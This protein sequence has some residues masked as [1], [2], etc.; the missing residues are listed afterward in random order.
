MSTQGAIVRVEMGM[1]PCP[2]CFGPTV[3]QKSDPRNV[4]TLEHGRFIAYETVRVC[5]K[6]CRHPSGELVTIRSDNLSRLVS[7]GCI[8]GYD[9]EVFVGLER[10][11]HHKQREEI[12]AELAK[13]GIILSS[14]EV[15]TLGLRFLK[16]LAELHAS[17]QPALREA[18]ERDGGY[19]LHF[20][21]TGE[22]GRGT[23]LVV[24]DG[25]REWVLGSWKLPTE[26]ADQ[27]TPHLVE[28]ALRFG[29]PCA[30]MRDLGRAVRRAAKDFVRKLKL[31]IPI[32]GCHLH[33][34]GDIG[35]DLLKA[36]HDRLRGLFQNAKL[37]PGLRAFV[38]DLGRKLGTDL[39]AIREEVLDWAAEDPSEHVLPEGRTG[40]A[41]LRALA[42]WVLD[43]ARDGKHLDF[44]FE[45]PYLDLY[46]RARTVRRAVDAFMRRPATGKALRRTLGRLARLLDP[47]VSM[48]D[49]SKA[50][51][52]IC[53]RAD[54][55]DELRDALRLHPKPSEDDAPDLSIEE[56][57][58]ELG[59]IRMAV[60]TL[61][62]SLRQRR[63]ERG[64][65]EDARK[66]IDIVLKH[67]VEHGNSLW[68]HVI[69]LPESA[70][71][72]IR[73]V[74][75]TN[76][77][78][79]SFFHRMKHGERRRSGRKVLTDDFENLPAEAAL[80]FNLTKPDYVKIVCGSLEELPNA[81][82][83]LD[84]AKRSLALGTHPSARRPA[85]EEPQ[86]DYASLPRA[87]RKIV[88]AEILRKRIEAAARSRAP[89]RS[90]ALG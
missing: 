55:F 56:T 73:I 21:A 89:R 88:R 48:K 58:A 82:A 25:W 87:D 28:V 17:R 39:P 80:A 20:D 57:A 40:L 53:T 90:V 47:V 22:D 41:T 78:L 7:A 61:K 72:G 10:F 69:I 44:P 26:R 37:L 24:Y 27:I 76:N 8:F 84:L 35:E 70:G 6:R 51:K 68:G 23:L 36:G 13:K 50:A 19:P 12:R 81:F 33:F 9:V 63:P 4:V 18:I 66:A 71:G 3:V 75:R 59:D 64:P 31:K 43:S 79:E 67:L 30:L 45:R 16:H 54:L 34:L 38:R 65:A 83:D 86:A 42:Q 52:T 74:A 5:A 32:L 77:L 46:E 14:G 49:F 62:R 1:V 85:V 15:S 11:V 29:A 2:Y 60:R